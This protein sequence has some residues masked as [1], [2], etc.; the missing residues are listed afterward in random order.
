MMKY[1]ILFSGGIVSKARFETT[2]LKVI[3][4]VLKMLNKILILHQ[5]VP[6]EVVK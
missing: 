3:L 2:D 1:W 6:K 4:L 5:S